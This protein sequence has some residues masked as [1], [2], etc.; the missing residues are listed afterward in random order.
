MPLFTNLILAVPVLLL[1]VVAVIGLACR[2]WRIGVGSVLI[3]GLW[4]WLI[5]PSEKRLGVLEVNG[6][7]ITLVSWP[8]DEG[9]IFAELS[10]KARERFASKVCLAQGAELFQ[11]LRA[12]YSPSQNAV[13]I[14]LEAEGN[15]VKQP[16]VLLL[17][18]GESRE[19][20]EAGPLPSD[21]AELVLRR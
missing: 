10:G 18:K 1:A 13:W 15:I 2:R 12:L 6:S 21:A 20:S 16:V 8:S 11:R 7:K 14:S 9:F 17:S 5:W 19:E 4:W 3:A